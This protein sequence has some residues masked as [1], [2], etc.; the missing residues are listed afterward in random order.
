[1]KTVH[2][3]L[4]HPAKHKE[5]HPQIHGVA[6][7]QVGKLRSMLES[8]YLRSEKECT[9]SIAFNH[10]ANGEQNNEVRSLLV[11]YAKKPTI[12]NG[13]L[14]ATRLQ[15]ATTNRS[16]L[17]LLFLLHGKNKL[18]TKLI[19]SRFP[20]NSGVLAREDEGTLSIEFLEKVFLRTATAYK[21]ALYHDRSFETGFWDG[22]CVDKQVNHNNHEI[23]S[24]WIKD[25]LLSDFKT[26]SAHGTRRLA[27][28]LR[29]AAR[30][31]ESLSVKE[32]LVQVARSVSRMGGKMTS[33]NDVAKKFEL[34]TKAATL[35]RRAIGGEQQYF[36]KFRVSVAEMEKHVG[37]E[38]VELD[39]GGILIAEASKF[40]KVFKQHKEGRSTRFS[41]EGRVVDKGLRKSKS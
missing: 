10:D 23:S 13:A 11:T 3:Y 7:Q 28:A 30:D 38:S 2:S 39:N 20:A 5:D 22:H 9:T 24:Y 15:E 12:E 8:I 14:I 35:L 19:V 27:N 6:L 36:E 29:T 21:A 34:S 17:G 26:T 31:A 37:Y 18:G 16:G 41:T 33:G 32:E 4:V 40:D 25:F 1:M